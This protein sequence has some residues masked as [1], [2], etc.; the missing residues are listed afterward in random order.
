MIYPTPQLTLYIHNHCL[1]G[2][3]GV[4]QFTPPPHSLFLD[5]PR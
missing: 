4:G 1:N 5:E 3:T 2:L